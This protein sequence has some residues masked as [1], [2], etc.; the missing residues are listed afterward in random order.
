M[1]PARKRPKKTEPAPPEPDV[2]EK[3]D[4]NHTEGDFLRALDRVA[5]NRAKQ[6]LGGPSRRG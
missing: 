6:R 4:A 5:T 3:Q 2:T 1:S